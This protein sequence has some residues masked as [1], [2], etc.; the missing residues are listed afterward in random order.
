[1]RRLLWATP[2][3]SDAAF[4]ELECALDEAVQVMW[5]GMMHEDLRQRIKAGA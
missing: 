4:E 2:A 3:S 5:D 1:L